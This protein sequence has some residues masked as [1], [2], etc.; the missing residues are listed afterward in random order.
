M[1]VTGVYKIVCLVN[2][3]VYIG[4]SGRCAEERI[5]KHKYKLRINKHANIH[6][7]RAY[8]KYGVANFIFEIIEECSKDIH[9]EREQYYK[10]VYNSTNP[11]FGYDM[12]PV[13]G[14]TLGKK[15]SDEAKA[16]M[17]KNRKGK[18]S[19]NKGIKLAESTKK[20][21]SDIFKKQ[22]AEGRTVNFKG[23]TH[24]EETKKKIGDFNRGWNPSEEIRLKMSESHKGLIKS[25]ETKKKLSDNNKRLE[26]WKVMHTPEAI[27]KSAA[28]K[29]KAIY[30]YDLEGNFIKE[31]PSIIEAAKQL[32]F[33]NKCCIDAVLA[34]RQKQ[35][36]GFIFKYKNK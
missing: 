17:S 5:R 15:H 8:N 14:T 16:K 30:Q 25:D 35:T 28:A 10:E 32:K 27:A 12:C 11:K 34:G 2:N 24:S 18:P 4:S 29:N 23:K 3:K 19:W 13:A 20:K 1:K 36:K 21:L 6:L 7:Q 33:H 9:L 22:F 31:Y 26:M